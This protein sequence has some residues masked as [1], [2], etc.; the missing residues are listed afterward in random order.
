MKK[1]LLYLP[2]DA[3]P[4][5]HAALQSALL[6]LASVALILSTYIYLVFQQPVWQLFVVIVALLSLIVAAGFILRVIRVGNHVRGMRL[7]IA[8]TIAETVT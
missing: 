1:R 2:D 5:A 8:A 4:Q 3:P 7:L 6:M